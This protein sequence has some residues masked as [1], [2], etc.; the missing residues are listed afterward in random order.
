MPARPNLIGEIITVRD[1]VDQLDSGNTEALDGKAVQEAM[2]ELTE[3]AQAD[4]PGCAETAE[5]TR[6]NNDV[7][8]GT[9]D[10]DDLWKAGRIGV[11][12]AAGT[13]GGPKPKPHRL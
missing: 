7:Q 13:I 4:A 5:I 6:I 9:L 1:T 3:A 11:R 12:I 10:A 8:G 2:G